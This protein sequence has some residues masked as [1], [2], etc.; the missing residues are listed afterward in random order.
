MAIFS[1]TDILYASLL[2]KKSSHG[3]E[4]RACGHELM[5]LLPAFCN[6]PVDVPQK[7]GSLAKLM[8]KFIKKKSFMHEAVALSLQV[9]LLRI[10]LMLG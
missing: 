8:V 4:L 5:R 10:S 6:Y 7:F 9:S 2:A 1:L 3:Q